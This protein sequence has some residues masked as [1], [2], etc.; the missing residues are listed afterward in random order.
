MTRRS[1]S[2]GRW[3]QEHFADPYVQR[4]QAA[5]WRSRAVFKLAEIDRRAHLLHPGA[6]CLDLGAAPG[7]WSQYASQRVGAKGRVVATDLLPMAELA[8]VEF[9]QGD[10]R[11]DEV[12]ERIL[13]LLPARGVDLVLSDMAPN[14]SG[15]DVIDQPRSMYLAELALAMAERVLKPGGSAL[16]KVFQGAGFKEL[17][18][19]ARGKFSEVKLMKPLASRSRSPESYL[20][21]MQ[22]RLV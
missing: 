11:E 1:R 6:V 13:A 8:G 20:L 22:Y 16:I 3:L 15:V 12:F 5:G 9:V 4:A 7:A 2:S 14:L 21:A 17:L 10:F 18:Q 19:A